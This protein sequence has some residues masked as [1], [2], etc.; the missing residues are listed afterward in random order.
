MKIIQRSQGTFRNVCMGALFFSITLFGGAQ[1]LAQA[2]WNQVVTSNDFEY[3]ALVT[4]Q[5]HGAITDTKGLSLDG[6]SYTRRELTPLIAEVTA[7]REQMNTNDKEMAMELYRRYM[8]EVMAYNV[9]VDKQEKAEKRRKKALEKQKKEEAKA[10]KKA[11]KKRRQQEKQ[12]KPSTE[13]GLGADVGNL[14]EVY[15]VQDGRNSSSGDETYLSYRYE[16]A[17]IKP[18]QSHGELVAQAEKELNEFLATKGD[19]KREE[20]EERALTDEQIKEKMDNFSIDARRVQVG[21]DV[22]I[23]YGKV[24][25][26]DKTDGRVRTQFKIDFDK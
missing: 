24:G 4:L 12:G 6:Q 26:K 14:P 19:E 13:A 7:K 8:D 9:A 15:Q 18:Q 25:D 22:R 10:A 23:R 5:E 16:P 2:D 21:G 20:P 3:K 1:A 11:E 17:P